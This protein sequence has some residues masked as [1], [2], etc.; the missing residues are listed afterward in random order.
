MAPMADTGVLPVPSSDLEPA[1]P[2]AASMDTPPPSSVG[3]L[4][5]LTTGLLTSDF[6]DYDLDFTTPTISVITL[7]PNNAMVLMDLDDEEPVEADPHN[8][9]LTH[10][11]LD[12]PPNTVSS[13]SQPHPVPKPPTLLSLGDAVQSAAD[14]A[15]MLAVSHIQ[16][17]CQAASIYIHHQLNQ[18]V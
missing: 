5:S 16:C 13:Y 17:A 8:S 15:F 1:H 18:P 12:T 9:S 10:P 2:V 3:S 7:S 11:A 14:A 6:L 4:S